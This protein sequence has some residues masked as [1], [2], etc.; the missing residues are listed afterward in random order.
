MIIPP[1]RHEILIE[2]GLPTLRFMTFLESLSTLTAIP[3]LKVITEDY[4]TSGN[5]FLVCN[6]TSSI[7]V[8]LNLTPAD[9]EYVRVKR[10]N[11]SNIAVK[12]LIDDD[13]DDTDNL[14]VDDAIYLIYS[15]A[16]S[17]WLRYAAFS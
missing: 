8:I 16:L 4:T 15:S 3:E 10:A 9:N 5:E 14:N 1:K 13:S 7:D 12:G 2:D 11:N 6:N 17:K